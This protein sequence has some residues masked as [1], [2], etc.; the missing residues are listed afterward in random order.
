[1]VHLLKIFDF[2]NTLFRSPCNT[3]E[4]KKLYERETGIPWE[5]SK[6]MAISLSK[7]L[8]KPIN[9]RS[10]WWGRP[11]TLQPPLV[12][13]PVPAE[14]WIEKSMKSLKEDLNTPG[15]M[16][17]IMTGRYTGLQQCLLRILYQ[18]GFEQA[19]SIPK[20][21]NSFHYNWLPGPIHLYLLGM[22]GPCSD[23]MEAKPRDAFSWKIWIIQQYRLYLQNLKEIQIWEDREEHVK[24]FR[25]L[26]NEFSESLVVHHVR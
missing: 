6:S 19:V 14:M 15:V 16:T 24:G 21:D 8:N 17:L 5:I 4:N 1:M 26:S 12:P 10:G 23:V 13:D 25:A 18:G 7:K 3:P 2:D 11:E 22:D 20:K 9:P